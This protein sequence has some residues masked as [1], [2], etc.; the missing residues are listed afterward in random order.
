MDRDFW[1]LSQ[2]EMTYR[3][4]AIPQKLLSW[5]DAANRSLPWRDMPTPYRVWISEIMLQQTRVQAALPYFNRFVEAIPDVRALAEVPDD[6]LMKLWEGLGYYSRARNLKRAAQII[7]REFDGVI[8]D[9][10]EELKRLPGIGEYTAG[11]IASIAYQRRT[12]AVDGN[13]MRTIARV[14]R[15]EAD[16]LSAATKRQYRAL[17]ME[18]M[19]DRPGDFNQALMEL[20]ALV[21][22]PNGAPNCGACPIAALCIAHQEGCETA[23]PVKAPKAPRRIEDQELTLIICKDAILLK[24][25]PK[26]GVLAGLWAF[27]EM[28]DPEQAGMHVLSEKQLPRARHI[29]THIEWRLRAR[30]IYVAERRPAPDGVWATL[31]EIQSRYAIPSAY[32]AYTKLL[33]E[34]L[35]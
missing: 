30:A 27:Y 28:P 18:M 8:P 29:F 12:A 25:R 34:L 23:L 11:A 16:I 31:S 21:C 14:F 32:R 10:A 17:L 2:D 33:P 4:A 35:G 6:Q 22:V 19:P 5:Y 15:N 3:M 20:G 9:T 13:V 7:V 24:K 26:S 1:M